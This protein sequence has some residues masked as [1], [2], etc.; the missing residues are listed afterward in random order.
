MTL[1]M[2]ML[3]L[4]TNSGFFLH[5]TLFKNIRCFIGSQLFFKLQIN[6]DVPFQRLAGWDGVGLGDGMQAGLSL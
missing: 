4:P 6:K 3:H 2:I 1:K 5:G